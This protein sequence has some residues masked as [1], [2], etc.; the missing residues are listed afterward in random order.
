M[1]EQTPDT[2][3]ARKLELE[4]ERTAALTARCEALETQAR[5]IS[6]TLSD[7]GVNAMPIP[8]GVRSLVQRCEALAAELDQLKRA[9]S[10]HLCEYEIA[11]WIACS[12]N[13]PEGACIVCESAGESQ[14]FHD[15]LKAVESRCQHLEQAIDSADLLMA[16]FIGTTPAVVEWQEW[17]RVHQFALASLLPTQEED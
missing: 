10:N 2:Y 15:H 13:H 14:H 16:R 12:G 5:S 4:R 9:L 11:D 7:A 6:V 17:R 1:S 8:D 3:L